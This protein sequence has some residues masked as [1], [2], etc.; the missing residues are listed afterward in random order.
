M[1][2]EFRPWLKLLRRRRSRLMTGALLMVLTVG[3]GAALLALSGWFITATAVAGMLLA[4]G[5]AMTLDV[6]VPGGGIR[7]FA[8]TRTVSRYL[9]RLY[10][11]DTVLRLLADLRAGM[12][13]VLVKLDAHTLSRRRASEWL[14]RLTADIDTLDSL[15]L[16]L[17]AP[18]AV[19]LLAIILVSGV[20]S[21][22]V[23][24][25]GATIALL[26]GGTWLWL[27]AGQAWWGMAASQ[28][29]VTTQETLRSHTIDHLQGLA[30][31][32]A[33]GSLASHHQ[34]IARSEQ[35]LYR[36][37]RRLAGMVAFGNAMV[38]VA[39]GM[40]ALAVLYLASWAYQEQSISAPVMVML[41]LA[42]LAMSEALAMLPMALTHFGATRSAARR[43]NALRQSRSRISTSNAVRYAQGHPPEV[44]LENV[45]L[46]YP[47]A[48]RPA[49]SN[50][51][52]RLAPGERVA[53]VG[54]SGAGKSSVA[55]LMARLV[56][57]QV[58][59]VVIGGIE[60]SEI[61]LD[62]WHGR[63]GYLTQQVELFHDSIAANLQIADHEADE[64]ALW[65]VLAMVELDAWVRQL[66][67]GLATMVGEG[68]AQLSGGQA[69]RL[70]LARVLLAEPE[71][72]IFDELFSGLDGELASRIS[73]RL[74]PWLQGRSVLFLVHQLE[75]GDV[76]PPGIDRAVILS[77]GGVVEPPLGE[78]VR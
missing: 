13:A 26:L 46:H 22:F 75:G 35:C 5:G 37:Q 18:P 39:V 21:I 16:R 15:Y 57:P 34:T 38:S 77:D 11:H 71:V 63:L 51:D 70:T 12:F 1:T 24:W 19:T 58:G 4:A 10:N 36:D 28:R 9:E 41:P 53:L 65:H 64:G 74:D 73:T 59:H 25:V 62:D 27:I 30:A 44:R 33:Y 31:L 48:P 17:L 8:V 32:S 56:E 78:A 52:L 67:H 29:R 50:L 3:S 20:A 72:V 66:P 6:Y 14:N 49:L 55:Q 7:F 42:V 60:V 69:R 43:L 40:T 23:P 68:G 47:G 45:T 76:D 2:N 61:V 54:P